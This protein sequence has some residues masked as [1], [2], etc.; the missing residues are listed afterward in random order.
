MTSIG[1]PRV[2]DTIARPD[3]NDAPAAT[4]DLD[5]SQRRLSLNALAAQALE[6]AQGDRALAGRLLA[7][8]LRDL[9]E[10]QKLMEQA[11]GMAASKAV[12][13]VLAYRR[14]RLLTIQAYDR[15]DYDGRA[16]ERGSSGRVVI[17]ASARLSEFPL[18]SGKVLGSAT[19][20]EIEGAIE[21]L[22]SNIATL[23]ARADWLSSI[24]QRLP[25]QRRV[26]EV[27]SEQDLERLAQRV[28]GHDRPK[29]L[30]Q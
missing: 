12:A 1:P 24:A 9:S 4:C 25:P 18:P 19:R 3:A 30:A 13:D 17:L 6:E 7:I 11:L 2:L 15:N 22:R 14:R 29:L 26:C 23:N 10:G 20:E 27:L 16:E 8:R 28:V 21:V 5:V